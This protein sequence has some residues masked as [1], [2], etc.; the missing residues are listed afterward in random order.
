MTDRR[1]LDERRMRNTLHPDEPRQ[2][3]MMRSLRGPPRRRR[4]YL[5]AAA[6][7]F[8]GLSGIGG[9]IGLLLDPTGA[10][11]GIPF[12]WLEGSPFRDYRLPGLVLLAALGVFPVVVSRGLWK[13]QAWARLGSVVVGVALTGWIAVEVLVVG[14]QPDPPLQAAYGALG[15]CI[16][17]LAVV[18]LIRDSEGP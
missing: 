9:G 10:L 4:Q 15:V 5:L 16:L 12:E 11:I 3:E 7:L 8:Q 2:R 1:L 17:G 13:Q 18:E 14:Y 6:V